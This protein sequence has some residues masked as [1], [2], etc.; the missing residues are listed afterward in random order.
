LAAG[1]NPAAACWLLRNACTQGSPAKQQQQQQQQHHDQH[2]MIRHSTSASSFTCSVS[3]H[4]IA[5]IMSMQV[6]HICSVPLVMQQMLHHSPTTAAAPQI[7]GVNILIM[8]IM[9]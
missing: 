5:E 3:Q 6:R 8:I 1:L 7:P 4:V 9:S 2:A